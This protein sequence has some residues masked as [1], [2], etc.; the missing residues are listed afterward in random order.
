MD[1]YENT[2]QNIIQEP[3]AAKDLINN[4]FDLTNQGLALIDNKGIIIKHNT[5][6]QDVLRVKKKL[7]GTSLYELIPSYMQYNKKNDIELEYN[8]RILKIT[9]KSINLTQNMFKI[10]TIV[11][12][13][14]SLNECKKNFNEESINEIYKIIINSIDE[15]IHA[16]DSNGNII[17]YN[18]ALEELEDYNAD[19][20]IGKHV[21]SIYNLNSKT[22]I[23]L[24][25]LDKGTPVLN[26]HQNYTTKNG[27]VIN[28]VTSTYPLYSKGK[29]VGSVAILKD[30]TAFKKL[31]EQLFNLQ[32]EITNINNKNKN[33]NLNIIGANKK[34]LE[35][36]TWARAAANT[37]SSV[38]IFGETGT[39]KEIF[40]KYIHYSGIYSNGPFLAINCAAIP[41]SLLEGLLFGTVKGAFTGAVDRIGLLEQANNGT[42]F[43]DELNSMPLSLQAKLLRAIEEKK[44]RRLGG[45]NEIDINPHII[46]SCNIDPMVAVKK[47][48]LRQDLFFRLAVIYI[49]I[50]PLRERLDDIELLTNYFINTF[51]KCLNKNVKALSNEVLKA[52]CKYNWPGNIRQLK[53]TIEGAMNIL[54]EDDSY[55]E[56]RHIP[57]YADLFKEQKQNIMSTTENSN[58]DSCSSDKN[59]FDM[60]EL[61]EKNRVINVLK[62]NRGNI[63]K[64]A[65]EL[66]ISRQNLQYKIKKFKLK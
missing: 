55:I 15:G 8:N 41:E 21:S 49:R 52:F 26:Y 56:K 6:L 42:F 53:Y 37:N 1:A 2:I 14:P 34:F 23:L 57:R 19:E 24:R 61:E 25:V 35:S 64:S 31:S 58:Y 47:K 18:S 59:L 3:N 39:G 5:V 28:V 30:F 13:Q 22:S 65:K 27:S 60:I 10:L 4:I 40:A 9:C 16:I 63:T 51:N 38:L 12:K 36:L 46:S 11:D 29:L 66:N 62:R 44:I 45:K 17:I 33:Y 50:P 7:L 54:T 20:V 43:L 48:K 32:K